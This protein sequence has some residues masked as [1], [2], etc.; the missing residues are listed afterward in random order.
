MSSLFIR[1]R[2]STRAK[3]GLALALICGLAFFVRVYYPFDTVFVG[4]WV[5]Y[6]INDPWHHMRV[7]EN[8]VHHF[9]NLISIDPYGF[10]PGGQPISTAPF[11]DLLLGFFI[12]VFGVGSPSPWLIERLGAFFPAILGALVTLPVYFIGKELFNRKAGLL[13]AALIAVL[14]GQFLM[15][16]LLGF[17]DHHVAEVLFATMTM[18]FL[19]LA[20]KSSRQAE[21]SFDA[22]RNRDW[23]V[24]RKPLI[25]SLLT[26]VALGLYL[27][28]WTG[29][30]LFIFIIVAF[31]VIQYIID[32]SVWRRSTD[33]LGIAVIPAFIV[34]LLM[35]APAANG[36]PLWNIQAASLVIGI[37]SF[38]ALSGTS[39]LMIRGNLHRYYYPVAIAAL[40][41]IGLVFFWRI[42][43]SL[44]NSM[45]DRFGVL[46]PM[47]GELTVSEMKGLPFASAFSHFRV[48]LYL[49]LISLGL[50]LIFFLRRE[51]SAE[52]TLLVVW[53]LV[54]LIATLRGQSRFEYYLAVNIALLSASSPFII[55]EL[56]KWLL[57]SAGF[58]TDSAKE[59]SKEL[60][61]YADL[62]T[63]RVQTK[64]TKKAKRRKE[65]SQKRTQERRGFRLLGSDFAQGMMAFI[66]IFFLMFYPIMFNFRNSLA[67]EW[68]G[69]TVEW[70]DGLRGATD[71]WQEALAWMS[72]N[73][74]EPFEDL[75]NPVFYY[76]LYQQPA[77]GEEYVYPDSAYGV[78]SW[79]DYGYWITYI[80]HRIPNAN[81][82][83]KNAETAG[84]YFIDQDET[85]ANGILNELGTKYVITDLEMSRGKFYAM[86]EW[87]GEDQ[88]KYFETYF[89]RQGNVFMRFATYYY[90]E[91]YESMC[92][93]LYNFEGEAVTPDNSTWVISYN[94]RINTEGEPFREITGIAN[95]APFP[96]YEDALAFVQA[97]GT[98]NYEIVGIDPSVSPVPLDKLDSYQ[99]V[100]KSPP[101]LVSLDWAPISFVKVFEYL[102]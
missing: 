91:Y 25:Y 39:I 17:T 24:L 18:L 32:H 41:V 95:N 5:R 6:Q 56:M 76:E 55:W 86:V 40:I 19:I 36:Y 37:I 75:D 12:W 10:F 51:R 66:F 4:D 22:L 7:V 85:S 48:N 3:Y 29:G 64:L 63:E 94:E 58:E 52:K 93:R 72:E 33:Y 102:P 96:T 78:M 92:S 23:G 81:P 61:R 16:S 101:K 62:K 71:D 60:D 79:W 34:A 57:K 13:A 15:R 2:E 30:A 26:G 38:V 100:H 14:P 11:Y 88:N 65:K 42:D 53:S 8:L 35:I 84:K 90:P 73:T 1:I 77:S 9:P 83:T 21:V 80:A 59:R 45:W 99:L 20:V 43:P 82:G 70:A 67:P 69:P 87:A 44:F 27:L 98:S 47:G 49:S 89:Q 50:I 54:M 28:S 74:P 68:P 97:Q 31:A 46:A